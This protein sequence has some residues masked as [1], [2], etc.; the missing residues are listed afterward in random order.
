MTETCN[1]DTFQNRHAKWDIP[2]DAE[3]PSISSRNEKVKFKKT[4]MHTYEIY[5]SSPLCRC[6]KFW[7]MLKP[8]V[9]R[10]TTKVNFKTLITRIC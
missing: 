9:Q 7:D 2:T 1:I 6:I 4:H 8:E 5:F 10:S 3:R